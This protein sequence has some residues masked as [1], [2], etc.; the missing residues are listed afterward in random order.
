MLTKL[1]VTVVVL[2]FSMM[3][4]KRSKAK[5]EQVEPS[6]DVTA[7]SRK[8]LFRFYAVFCLGALLIGSAAFMGWRYIDN[9][10]LMR[11]TITNPN[12]GA[13]VEYLAHKGD[14]ESKVLVT[15]DGQTIRISPLESVI[16]QLA[17]TK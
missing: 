17:E 5:T 11:V 3:L 15:V 8:A 6:A 4:L 13:S 14:I 9:Q 7:M 10:Q 1:L 2:I 16:I 12:T